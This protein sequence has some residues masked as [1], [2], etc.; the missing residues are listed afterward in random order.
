[1][2]VELLQKDAAVSQADAEIGQAKAAVTRSQAEVE[3]AKSQYERMTKVGRGGVI[4]KD[5][6]GGRVSAS[7]PRRLASPRRR[8]T[9]ASPRRLE[10]ARKTR[11]YAATMVGFAK[12]V[13]P[14][15]GVV[16]QRNLNDGDLVQPGMNRSA[17]PLY[18]VDQIDRM[19]VVVNV[20][21]SDAAWI[22]DGAESGR[23]WPRFGRPRAQGGPDAKRR[24]V[25]SG[26]AH[27]ADRDRSTEPRSP[28]SA[29][30]MYVENTISAERKNAWSL[31]K[32]AI[33]FDQDRPIGY[34][35][36]E[37]KTVR[38]PLR[39]GLRGND[40][41]ELLQKQAAPESADVQ[42]GWQDFDGTETFVAVVGP[43]TKDGQAVSVAVI[44]KK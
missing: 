43:E 25:E 34:R 3:R 44:E 33:V 16:S 1:M 5:V 15:E 7:R 6:D 23:G 22:R 39:V 19:R 4:G 37:G 40:L 11:D 32:S 17:K 18:F 14:F 20:P 42:G 26:D 9:S 8:R 10:V 12:I 2:D 41:V 28:A 29:S 27:A 24:G 38:T 35:I 21:E 13:A 36:V 30:G 31:P